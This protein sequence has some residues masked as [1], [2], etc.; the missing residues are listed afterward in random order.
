MAA[1]LNFSK[2]LKKSLAYL[3]IVGNVISDFM[4]WSFCAHKTFWSWPL[5]AILKIG[6]IFKKSL[7]HPHVAR[8]VMLKFQKQ[9]TKQFL[10]AFTPLKKLKL[11]CGGHFEF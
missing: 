11:I 7:A 2:T 8:N 3:H 10:W 4:F 5:A 1:I 9:L 6:S